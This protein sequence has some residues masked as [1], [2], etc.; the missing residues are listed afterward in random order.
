MTPFL[1]SAQEINLANSTSR[2]NGIV[3]KNAIVPKYILNNIPSTWSILDFGAGKD[4][5]H[6]RML[7]NAGFHS[8]TA[9]EFGENFKPGFHYENALDYKYN[10][11]FASNVINVQS[12]LTMLRKTLELMKNSTS[13]FGQI[14]FNYPDNP[15]HLGHTTK[16]VQDF[17]ETFFSRKV[18][19]VGGT[20][21][22][23][24]WKIKLNG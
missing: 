13:Y 17:I 5:Q 14:I 2:T 16:D 24:I 19:Q 12:N 18:E 15:R 10:V 7:R 22:A 23:P 3:G 4:A 11:V 20:K 8:V 9:H 21:N 1:F 6:T